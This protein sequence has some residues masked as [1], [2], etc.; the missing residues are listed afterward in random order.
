MLTRFNLQHFKK[1]ERL[2]PE[3]T[4]WKYFMQICS[5]LDHMHSRRIMHRGNNS[6][7]FTVS[8]VIQLL[9]GMMDRLPLGK[10][11]VVSSIPGSVGYLSKVHLRPFVV[12]W[13][14]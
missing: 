1:Q 3:K 5:A 13:V 11:K 9:F 14:S 4:I 2:I 6:P 8:N 12:I 7:C 10:Q